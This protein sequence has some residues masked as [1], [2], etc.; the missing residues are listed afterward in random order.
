MKR[1]YF[2]KEYFKATINFIGELIGNV[3]GNVTGNITGKHFKGVDA[4]TATSGSAIT[5]EVCTLAHDSTPIAATLA[6]PVAGQQLYI[7]NTSS[8]GTAAHTVKCASGVTFDGTNN[9]ATFNAPAEALDLIALSATR[10]YIKT[11]TG[12]VGLSS[13]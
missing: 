1:T 2:T 13:T 8:T 6:A 3:V 10:W 5:K 7:L 9:T 11:N 12:S 4:F